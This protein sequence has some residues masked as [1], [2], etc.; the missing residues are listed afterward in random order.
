M[1]VL[2][3]IPAWL[4]K[5]SRPRAVRLAA[6]A[7]AIVFVAGTALI[8]L[9]VQTRGTPIYHDLR[10]LPARPVAIVFGAGYTRAGASL[11][12]ADRVRTAVELYRA[13]KVRKLLMTGDNS[14]WDYNEPQAMRQTA[15]A[16]GVPPQDIV[17]DYAGFRT[18]DSLYRARDIFGVRQA[19]LVTQS[20]HLPRALYIGRGLGMDVVGA[21]ADRHVYPEQRHLAVREM[22]SVE[23]AWFQMHLFHPRPHFLGRK[24]PIAL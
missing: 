5:A 16:L 24:E 3:S 1:R 21:A 14:R 2:K 10:A 6:G 23:N 13:R 4:R 19:V 17:L 12:L 7:G 11:I 9:D 18:Y 15:L 20:Y 8:Y 22:F